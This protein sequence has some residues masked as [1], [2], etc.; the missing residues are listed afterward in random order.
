MANDAKSILV[1]G[2]AKSGT[3]ALFYAIRNALHAR[4]EQ[5]A[6]L[7]EP[8]DRDRIDAY[9]ATS[10]DSVRLVKAMLSRTAD[11]IF[12]MAGA[13]DRIVLIVRDPRDNIVSHAAF[14]PKDL[15]R[16]DELEK[17]ATLIRLFEGKEKDPAS[18][19]VVGMI[20]RMGELDGR[21]RLLETMRAN[22]V[23]SV[24]LVREHHRDCMVLRYE[25]MIAGRV[26]ALRAYL[27]LAVDGNPELEEHHSFVARSKSSGEWR[28]WFLD[29]DID[30]FVAP[31]ANEFRFLGYDPDE[32]P[33]E[34]RSIAPS[35]CS[36]Y[37][38]RQFERLA[39][40]SQQP[41]K[42]KTR[43]R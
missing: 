26:E 5:V 23:M 4:G 27:G 19:S 41:G 11:W 22:S 12:D 1:L 34:E 31:L 37:V 33:N 32:R 43:V 38:K 36:L 6:G 15:V 21:P 24:P 14:K 35:A 29:E 2:A 7:L 18:I 30:V 3:T 9:L 40:L 25:D 17:Q 16:S 20:N 39:W 42:T 28:D 13:F 10:N 8:R